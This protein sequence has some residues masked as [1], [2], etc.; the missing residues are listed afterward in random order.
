MKRVVGARR[1]ASLAVVAA[2]VVF[3]FG[4]SPAR[5]QDDPPNATGLCTASATLSNGVTVDPYASAGTYPIPIEG[6]ADYQGAVEAD[7]ETPR[8][9]SGEVTI[10]TPPGIPAVTVTEAWEWSNDSSDA[11]SD[12]GSVSWELPSALPRGVPITVEGFHQDQGVRCEGSITVELEGGA[13]DSPLTFAALGGTVLAAVGL[14]FAGLAGGGGA[15]AGGA[16]AGGAG[17][18]GAGAGGAGTGPPDPTAGTGGAP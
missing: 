14:G 9:I 6:S 1:R 13:F 4:G 2:S 10:R 7:V 5:A 8:P 17:A 3:V 11:L 18:G 16:G 15:G 12:S